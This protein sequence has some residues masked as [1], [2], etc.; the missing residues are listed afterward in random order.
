MDE[1]VS[2]ENCDPFMDPLIYQKLQ[3]FTMFT[4]FNFV[5]GA[6]HVFHDKQD[7]V[8]LMLAMML[9]HLHETAHHN[10]TPH[11]ADPCSPVSAV[12]SMAVSQGASRRCY[13]RRASP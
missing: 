6:V 2:I 5:P 10:V 11:E 7:V 1:L 12:T 3:D 9:V 13:R 8:Q 4:V